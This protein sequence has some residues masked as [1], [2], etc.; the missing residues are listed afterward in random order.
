MTFRRIMLLL[1]KAV[2]ALIIW[3][4]ASFVVLIL[5]FNHQFTTRLDEI[6]TLVGVPLI[7]MIGYVYIVFRVIPRMLSRRAP[8]LCRVCG[9]DLRATPPRCPECGASADQSGR[10]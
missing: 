4:A 6:A 1:I 2:G 8:G 10:D 9:Y 7:T 5:S 3:W